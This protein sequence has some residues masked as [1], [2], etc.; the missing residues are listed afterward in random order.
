MAAKA[1]DRVE[2]L[3]SHVVACDEAECCALLRLVIWRER[4]GA[5]AGCTRAGVAGVGV[6]HFL[7]H[8]AL[9]QRLTAALRELAT[10][11]TAA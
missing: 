2:V 6:G 7:L 5:L 11:A 4:T 9:V 3:S 10:Q 1:R 8:L